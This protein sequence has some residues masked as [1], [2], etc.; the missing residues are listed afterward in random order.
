MVNW[1]MNT[2]SPGLR[3]FKIML[4]NPLFPHGLHLAF[5]YRHPTHLGILHLANFG[6]THPMVAMNLILVKD[7]CPNL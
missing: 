7:M 2:M 1:S 3:D 4:G 6:S 5:P